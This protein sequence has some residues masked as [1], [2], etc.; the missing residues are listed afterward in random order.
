MSI[1]IV[2]AFRLNVDGHEVVVE[3]PQ[4]SPHFTPSE[5]KVFFE[6]AKAT[7]APNK[8]I[9]AHALSEAAHVGDKQGIRKYIQNLR[10]KLGEEYIKA[11][12]GYGY[13]IGVP[14]QWDPDDRSPLRPTDDTPPPDDVDDKDLIDKTLLAYRALP[15]SLVQSPELISH[16][17]TRY[18]C[19]AIRLFGIPFAA[20]SLWRNNNRIV[21]PDAVLGFLDQEPIPPV[22]LRES[23]TIAAHEYQRARLLIKKEYTKGPVKHEGKDYRMTRSDKGDPPRIQGAYGLYYDSILTQYAMEW[24][25]N[26]V[27]HNRGLNGINS[28]MEPGTL[29]RREAVEALGNPLYSGAG[30]CAALATSTLLVFKNPEYEG[31]CCLIR[32]R[33]IFVGVSPGMLHVIPAGMFEARNYDPWSVEVNVW[34]EL[35]EE[36]Y[37]DKEEQG[38]E[39]PESDDRVRQKLPVNRLIEMINK[40]RSAEFSVTGI[41]CDLLSLRHEICTILFVQDASFRDLR[42]MNLNWEYEPASWATREGGRFVIPL[43]EVNAIV[44]VAA[45]TDGITA[46]GAACLSFGLAWLRERHGL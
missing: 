1:L 16:L 12:K 26:K 31:F 23:T 36:V 11:Q 28:L 25:L 13:R 24:E 6:L 20:T 21:K 22:P 37:N 4:G 34:R 9:D 3:G 27:L 35:L 39:Q 46:T 14:P 42:A 33:S 40:D 38:S 45:S 10:E 2:G 18:A 41:C 17:E 43:S 29:P 19:K 30:R 15:A 7:G 32:R 5:A 44:Q 8:W